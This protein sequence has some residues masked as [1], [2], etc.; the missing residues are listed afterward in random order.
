[1]GSKG[2]N[3]SERAIVSQWFFADDI[4]ECIQVLQPCENSGSCTN[5]V[6][7][8]TCDC[9]G[10]GYMGPTCAGRNS[11]ISI[12]F[13]F[14]FLNYHLYLIQGSTLSIARLPGAGKT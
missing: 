5:T 9:S 13:I 4:D 1:M 3:P 14:L 12:K 11:S 7:S 6:G 2:L 8:F 10:T